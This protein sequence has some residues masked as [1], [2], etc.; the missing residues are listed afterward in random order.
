MVALVDR[1]GHR[2]GKLV[3]VRR[4]GS[5]SRGRPLWF[6]RCDCGG[7]A[8]APA[9]NLANGTTRS[10]G[11]LRRGPPHRTTPKHDLRGRRFGKLTVTSYVGMRTGSCGSGA[12]WLCVCDCGA[13]REYYAAALVFGSLNSC[14]CVRKAIISRAAITHG[15]SGTR[16]YRIWQG[17]RS[18]C[19]NPRY[20]AYPNYGG[21]GIGICS[22]WDKFPQFLADMGEPPSDTH[23][24][25][26]IDNNRGYEPG[27][28]RWATDLDQANNKRGS[29]RFT[30]E[31]E[32][33]TLAE[34]C[35]LTGVGYFV[36]HG[37][38]RQGKTIEDALGLKMA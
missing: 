35:R 28:C 2:Y 17:I 30:I 4:A 6:C 36:A 19:L 15:R 23:S 33:R 29:R 25:E 11:C 24:I 10:C 26:R 7:T 9:P 3:V 21:R 37:R 22:R 1:V 8:N 13:E 27:N 34:W 16:C 12:H 14:G 31:G 38:L 20:H 18:R 5:N 32:T